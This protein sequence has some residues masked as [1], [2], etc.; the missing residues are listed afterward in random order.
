MLD[1]TLNFAAALAGP[2]AAWRW[3]QTTTTRPPTEPP[4][5]SATTIDA[6]GGG[7]GTKAGFDSEFL[8]PVRNTTT[9][10]GH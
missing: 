5:G 9:V 2:I 1:A 6:K 7:E 3:Y 10:A 8:S 4:Y